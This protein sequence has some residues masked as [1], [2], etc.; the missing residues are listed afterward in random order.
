L[1]I[2]F[3]SDII[4]VCSFFKNSHNAL[5]DKNQFQLRGMAVL[6]SHQKK[7]LGKALI[8]FGENLLHQKKASIVWCNARE[9]AVNFYKN[10]GFDIISKPFNIPNIGIHYV[11][12]KS[13]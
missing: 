2:Y 12:S 6:K 3:K 9:I 4:G 7:G 8:K 11:M 10:N 13:L 5:L 1:G